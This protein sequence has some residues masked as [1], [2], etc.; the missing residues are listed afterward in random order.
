[1]D[2]GEFVISVPFADHLYNEKHI[3]NH[4]PLANLTYYQQ[5]GT[6]KADVY[7]LKMKIAITEGGQGICSEAGLTFG[8]EF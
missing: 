7:Y 4:V 5:S 8:R 1:M 3:S 2:S 6:S